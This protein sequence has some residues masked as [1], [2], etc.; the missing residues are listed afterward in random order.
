MSY[1][2]DDGNRTHVVSLEGWSSTIELHP[3]VV[4]EM[5]TRKGLEPSTH[6]LK[7]SCSTTWANGSHY[8]WGT[9]I[10]T[11]EMPESKS[12]A[13]PLGYTPIGWW[14]G[15]DSNRRTRRELIYSQPRLA[16]S[17]P[18]QYKYWEIRMV[19]AI[20]LEPTTYWLQISC[21]A[22][23]AKPAI[24]HL[25]KNGGGWGTRTPDPLLVRQTLSQLS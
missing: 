10:R 1:G 13:L 9:W 14:G 7:V 24:L 25:N 17:L 22:N 2:A 4:K 20:G 18:P 15:T 12:G 16:T 23:W 8:G 11:R 6:W 21:S 19:P 5:V 3:R